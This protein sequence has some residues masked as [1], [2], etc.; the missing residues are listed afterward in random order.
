MTFTTF[1][2][3][4]TLTSTA[5]P[6]LSFKSIYAL[7]QENVYLLFFRLPGDLPRELVNLQRF[8]SD[9][10]SNSHFLLAWFCNRNLE[11]RSQLTRSDANHSAAF[12]HRAFIGE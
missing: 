7:L 9:S 10:R 3:D 1:R 12:D 4:H 5:V 8:K 2:A 11:S 6:R